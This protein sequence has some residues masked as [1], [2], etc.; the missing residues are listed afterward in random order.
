[1]SC[2]VTDPQYPSQIAVLHVLSQQAEFAKLQSHCMRFGILTGFNLRF[3]WIESSSSCYSSST[4][5]FEWWDMILAKEDEDSS[6]KKE[7]CKNK[8]GHLHIY[9]HEALNIWLFQK[10]EMDGLFVVIH[11][12]S[13]KQRI[14]NKKT[15]IL[16]RLVL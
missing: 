15:S 13:C 14:K 5:L 8:C 3:L 1:M 7:K 10:K 9:S 12:L 16:K 2:S 11:D 4:P 6:T